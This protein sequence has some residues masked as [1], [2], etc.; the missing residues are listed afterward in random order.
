M[1]KKHNTFQ[2]SFEELLLAEK[3]GENFSMF[4]LKQGY[5]SECDSL[6]HISD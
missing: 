4:F 2:M 3:Q 5:I 1:R 6:A